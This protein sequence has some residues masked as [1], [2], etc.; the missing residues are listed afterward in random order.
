MNGKLLKKIYYLFKYAKE[1]C[2]PNNR[3]LNGDRITDTNNNMDFMIFYALRIYNKPL[4]L[5]V[6]KRQFFIQNNQWLNS[7]IYH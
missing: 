4:Q 1:T 7:I 5:F 6:E 3:G 2:K